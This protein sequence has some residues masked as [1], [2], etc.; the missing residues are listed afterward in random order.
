MCWEGD[1]YEP[2]PRDMSQ[3][4]KP[5][6]DIYSA[7]IWNREPREYVGVVG[8][9]ALTQEEEACT[10]SMTRPSECQNPVMAQDQP[11]DVCKLEV[12]RGRAESGTGGMPFRKRENLGEIHLCQSGRY[13]RSPGSW[14]K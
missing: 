14:L 6:K 1:K 2:T 7:G 10:D 13:A 11:K 12:V 4:L 5:P 8:Y 9:G 3:G